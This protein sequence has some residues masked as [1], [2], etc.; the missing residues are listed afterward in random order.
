MTSP[1][2]LH[3]LLE[4]RSVAVVGASA[5]PGSNGNIMVRQLIGGGFSGHVAAVNPRYDEVE[6]VSC[7]PS[8]REVPFDVDLAILGVPN[9]VLEE[10]LS[11]AAELSVPA[12]VIYASGY[13]DD[14]H[15][16]TL[17]DRLKE[18]AL[19]SDISICGGN[20]MGFVNFD[21]KLRALAFEESLDMPGGGI[22][23]VTHSGSA[24]TALLHNTRRLRFNLAISAGQEFTTT[25]ADYISYAVDQST[26]SV[27][28]LF[29]ETIRDPVGFRAALTKAADADVPV[30]ALKVGRHKEARALVAAHSGA[31]A[32]EDA[33]YEAL[34]EAHGVMRVDSF[35][36][37]AETL[38][39]LSSKR[40]A[41]AGGLAAIHDSGGERAHLVDAAGALGL[42][43]AQIS[44]STVEKLR[45][46]LEPGLPAVNPL[47]AWGTGNDFDKIFLDC[48]RALL[49]DP[50][51]A[52]FA[53]VV[54]L[55][56]EL[57]D[58]GY[59]PI[60]QQVFA[61]TSKPLAVLSNLSSAMDRDATERLRA[62]GV[63]VLEDTFNGLRAFAHLLRYR[64]FQQLAPAATYSPV[65]AETR[66]HWVSRLGDGRAL[67]EAES[68]ELLA[69]YG[70]PVAPTRATSSLDGALE[71]AWEIGY[72]VALKITG[73]LH[74]SDVGGVRTMISNDDELVQAHG[75]LSSRF[76]GE[77]IVQKMAPPGV[78]MALGMVRD[79][80]FGP[81]LVVAAGGVFVE[82]LQDRVVG[83]P[84]LDRER[85]TSMI[86]RLVARPL[87][88]GARGAPAVDVAGFADALVHLS[89]LATDLG[90]HIEALD[91]NPVIVSEQG[92]VIVDALVEPRSLDPGSERVRPPLA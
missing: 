88:D 67:P 53:F 38:E 5:R 84:P 91:A 27:I 48:S 63:P 28:A 74:K 86:D 11:V 58:W 54:D 50:D 78:E 43:F 60:A 19:Q 77:L 35:N 26:T 34:F 36:E 81:V 89:R 39:L 29:I 82:V 52:A 70:L 51:T 80:Q 68:L 10:Q 90:D 21:K 85:A 87:L 92:C 55:A 37:M 72:P 4:P 65:T 30:V 62:A 61:E 79:P 8:L 25:V 24:F 32:G 73:S 56:G 71:A 20:C 42:P 49:A 15:D 3:A 33:T 64:D 40:R 41:V 13:P 75:E 59:A 45:D 16:T 76:A 18:I 6:G 9:A 17:I 47:D 22:A 12:A 69:E 66:A 23:W 44:R 2:G 46:T 31:L 7:F 1:R 57:P 83:L 14:P